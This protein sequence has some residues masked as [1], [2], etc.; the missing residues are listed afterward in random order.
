[1]VSQARPIRYC[2][3]IRHGERADESSDPALCDLFAGATDPILTPKGFGQARQTGELLLREINRIQQAEGR[4]FDEIRLS[5]SPFSRCIS[6]SAEIG[7][8]I[9]V[10]TINIDYEWCEVLYSHFFNENPLPNLEV[11]KIGTVGLA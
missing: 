2:Y 3:I 11:R 7:R 5:V 4:A 9:G 8:Q 1:M 10:S 6:T